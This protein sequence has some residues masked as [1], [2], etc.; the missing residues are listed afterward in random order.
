MVERLVTS[1]TAQGHTRAEALQVIILSCDRVLEQYAGNNVVNLAYMRAIKGEAERKWRA[2]PS[3]TSARM[4]AR[5][6][7]KG[8]AE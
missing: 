4:R 2:T 7:W 8:K 1:V 3:E 6:R 5:S